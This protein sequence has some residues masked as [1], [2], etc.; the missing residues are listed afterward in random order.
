MP[1]GRCVR[2]G[3]PPD[4]CAVGFAH[5]GTYGC[6]PVLPNE[7]CPDGLMAVP[8]DNACRPVMACAEGQ[9]G[10]I[11]IDGTTEHVDASYAGT[12]SDGSASK[13]WR[14]IG[15]AITAAA[16][17][18]LVAVAEGSYA[19]DVVI[20][21][22]PVRL[23]GV[24]P[25]RVE[26]V[27][28]STDAALSILNQASGSEIHGVSMRG[29]GFGL[30]VTGSEDVIV[31]RVWVRVAGLRGVDIERTFGMTSATIEG[32]LI[33]RS[34]VIGVYVGGAEL[35]LEASL[36]RGTL[37]ASNDDLGHGVHI[38]PSCTSAGC[39]PSSRSNALVRGS[40]VE[41]NHDTG[42]N[43]TG[44]DAVI[45]ATVVR[46]TEP[47][48]S[49]ADLGRGLYFGPICEAN[50]S[51]TPNTRTNATV[52]GSFVEENHDTGVIV[53]GSDVVVETSVVRATQ[54]R[55][56]DQVGGRGFSIQPACGTAALCEPA[57][58]A[59]ATIVHSLVDSNHEFGVYVAGSEAIVENSV[60][61]DT[62]PQPADE[63]FGRGIQLQF[64]CGGSG[65]DLNMPTRGSIVGSLV[66]QNHE[67]GVF[68]GGAEARVEATLISA[69]RPQAS[70][71]RYGDGITLFSLAL[72]AR[73]T[74]DASRIEDS[75]RAGVSSFGGFVSIGLSRVTCAS[76]DMEGEELNGRAFVFEDRGKNLCGCPTAD[77]PC[78]AVSVALEAPQPA[79]SIGE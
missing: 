7:T 14:T 75:A 12:D 8:G 13:P 39:D 67:V 10:D 76:F 74:I 5:D 29:P 57:T 24:C 48:A 22:K 46:R 56:V 52:R 27:G 66:T 33:E 72:E 34:H 45:E 43:I 69:T 79:G 59:T 2:P 64:P 65:C 62:R 71:D 53:L 15:G 51:C 77:R 30:L 25:E 78:E 35:T 58:F 37:P 28:Q 19:E 31:D 42:M 70:N 9:W 47:R 17:G 3:I 44:S 49:D 6:T 63:Q 38:Q 21:N 60:V 54:P 20:E 11:P 36:V 68:L 26:I 1:D 16:S 55:M 18:A 41:Q 73:A 61:R 4:G 23:W 40:L 32:A 50:S